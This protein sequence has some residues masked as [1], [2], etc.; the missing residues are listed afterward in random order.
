MINFKLY[1]FFKSENSRT[2][3]HEA[4]EHFLNVKEYKRGANK[5]YTPL[6]KQNTQERKLL[7]MI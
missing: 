4:S 7:F 3:E 5:D 2:I 6:K 1:Y